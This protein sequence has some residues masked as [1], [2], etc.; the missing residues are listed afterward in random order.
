MKTGLIAALAAS[1]VPFAP[2]SVAA[3]AFDTTAMEKWSKVQIVHYEVV[4]EF[5]Q[6]NVQI[7]PS[8]RISTP[9]W[10]SA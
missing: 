7:P 10:S 5:R 9:M 2:G 1:V 3:Q 6:K 4:G 8:T